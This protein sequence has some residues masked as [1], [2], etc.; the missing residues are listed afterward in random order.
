MTGFH[1]PDDSLA[2]LINQSGNPYLLSLKF[3]LVEHVDKDDPE[4][5]ILLSNR[6]I[7]PL[8]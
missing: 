3:V 2:D 5:Q 8:N 7:V 1:H 4:F 6:L